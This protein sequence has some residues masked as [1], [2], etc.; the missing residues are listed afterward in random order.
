[1]RSTLLSAAALAALCL[2]SAAFAASMHTRVFTGSGTFTVPAN[3]KA[4]QEFLF[5]VIGGGGG[6]G[7]CDGTQGGVSG[8][9]GSGGAGFASC[10]GF[11][12]SDTITVAVGTGGTGGTAGGGSAGSGG[13]TSLTYAG[14]AIVSS[15][16]GAGS[17]GSPSGFFGSPGAGGTFT[18]GAGSTGL[19]LQA[20]LN[21]VAPEGFSARAMVSTPLDLGTVPGGANPLGRTGTVFNHNG[22]LG[23][24]GLGCFSQAIAGGSGG[25]GVVIVTWVQ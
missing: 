23:G 16:G 7:G 6:A 14:T 21:Y 8:G 11:N 24:G 18:A 3:A 25:T 19:T 5:T 22:V 1:M 20:S 2:G 9:G 15:T 17:L 13:T 10:S 12:P 4:A